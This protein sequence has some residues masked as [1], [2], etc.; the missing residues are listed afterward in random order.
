LNGYIDLGD[1]SS[2][3]PFKDV[4]FPINVD[5][6]TDEDY[7][8][9]ITI[10]TNPPANSSWDNREPISFPFQQTSSWAC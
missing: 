3:G 2:V 8:G 1:A 5:N 7:L 6:I 9:T 4:R 10:T